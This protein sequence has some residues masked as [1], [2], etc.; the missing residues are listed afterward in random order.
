MPH[1]DVTVIADE[2]VNRLQVRIGELQ[3]E[4]A[5]LRARLGSPFFTRAEA[6]DFLRVTTRTID[7]LLS[8]G[9]LPKPMIGGRVRIRRAD[10]ESLPTPAKPAVVS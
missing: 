10:L 3:G 1:I 2:Q 6:A 4:I 7:D 5:S 8:A 9:K